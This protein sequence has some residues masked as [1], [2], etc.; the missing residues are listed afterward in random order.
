MIDFVILVVCLSITF[1][2]ATVLRMKLMG[3][4]MSLAIIR[5]LIYP[6]HILLIH[7]RMYK[8]YNNKPFKIRLGILLMPIIK[9]QE[10]IVNYGYM[11]LRI[12]V[13]YKVIKEMLKNATSDNEKERILNTL[14]KEGIIERRV[15]KKPVVNRGDTYLDDYEKFTNKGIFRYKMS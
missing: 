14:E 15:Y 4:K 11:H 3:M 5:S 2:F 13:T 9:P 12:D 7:Y 1:Y 8:K 6:I 10:T